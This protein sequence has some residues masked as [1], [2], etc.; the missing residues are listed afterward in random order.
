[1][2][3]DSSPADPPSS[4]DPADTDW[5]AALA[6]LTESEGAVLA[7][8]H[9]AYEG[10]RLPFGSIARQLGITE[11]QA[12][13]LHDRAIAKL[14]ALPEGLGL[15]AQL[16]HGREERGETTAPTPKPLPK[17]VERDPPA[18]GADGNDEEPDPLA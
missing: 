17:I 3:A 7:L 13:E 2:T 16:E 11:Q 4:D 6:R 12:E 15:V 14:R 1:M 18:T 8:R 10:Q 9:G 5:T